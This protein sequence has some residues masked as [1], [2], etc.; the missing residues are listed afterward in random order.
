MKNFKDLVNSKNLK[1]LLIIGLAK[2]LLILAIILIPD[3]LSAQ[4]D[5]QL[6]RRSQFE[7]LPITS[8][9]IVFLGNSI[10]EGGL[11]SEIF[12]NARVK[13]RGIGGETT[14]QVLDRLYQVTNGKPKK[15]FLMIGINDLRDDPAMTDKAIANIGKIIDRIKS[16]SPKTKLYV[17]SI[18][19]VSKDRVNRDRELRRANPVIKRICDEKGVTFIDLYSAFA[20]EEGYLN[21]EYTIKDGLHLNGTGYMKWAEIVRPHVK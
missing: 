12:N 7:L 16:E 2:K 15:V 20:D 18:L 11:W 3:M 17:Q 14:Q 21:K 10:T 9:D 13:N 4:N 1:T 5:Q 8:K 6:R 19:P